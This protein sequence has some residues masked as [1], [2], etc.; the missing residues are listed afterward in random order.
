MSAYRVVWYQAVTVSTQQFID[1][2]GAEWEN[3][4]ER[5]LDEEAFARES[6]QECDFETLADL[7]VN[8][9]SD[10]EWEPT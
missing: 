6:I 4:Q 10:L 9:V 2:F 8:Y 1:A 5:G 7:G 3:A